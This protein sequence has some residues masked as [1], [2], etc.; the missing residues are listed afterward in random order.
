MALH[1][2]VKELVDVLSRFSDDAE[3]VI[4][5][6]V[7]QEVDISVRLPDGGRDI[8]IWDSFHGF[9]SLP[10][11]EDESVPLTL[12]GVVIGKAFVRDDATAD[13]HINEEMKH[14]F[15][16]QFPDASILYKKENDD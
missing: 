7:M 13:I 9:A 10:E 14:L 16:F 5:G 4:H 15:R 1:P 3:V 2:T 6:D 11:A 12:D 8:D